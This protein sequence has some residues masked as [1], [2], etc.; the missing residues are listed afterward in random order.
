MM[1]ISEIRSDFSTTRTP[2]RAMHASSSLRSP[3]V[4]LTRRAPRSRRRRRVATA[5]SA[6][7][8]PFDDGSKRAAD[9]KD[10]AKG[11]WQK[12]VVGAKDAM[13]RRFGGEPGADTYACL[14]R[15]TLEEA[16]SGAKKPLTYSRTIVCPECDGD[17]RVS[18]TFIDCPRCDASGKTSETTDVTVTVPP[19]VCDGASLRLK[20]MG[21]GGTPPGDLYV[22][23]AADDMS[24]GAVIR[25]DGANLISDLVV[26]FEKRGEDTS[27]RVRTV[28]GEHGTLKVRADVE[29]GQ[30]LRIKGRGA[31]VKPGS[32]ERGDHLFVVKKIIHLDRG[33]GD[34][35][36]DAA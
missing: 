6:I 10:K 31:P 20:E 35:D 16:V 14:P 28:E 12:E 21:G 3:H 17:G 15:I 19:G 23:I 22:K 13:K 1:A 34:G 18:Q 7:S 29:V 5:P 9:L 11:F 25:R 27:A 26:R 24:E 8:N 30:A 2:S 4:A 33:S 36:D 32:E